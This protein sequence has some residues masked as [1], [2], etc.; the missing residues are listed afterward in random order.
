MNTTKHVAI[1]ASNFFG[2]GFDSRRLH[3]TFSRWYAR[4]AR[5]FFAAGVR[6][7]IASARLPRQNPRTRNVL[8]APSDERAQDIT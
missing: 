4:C 6:L 5:D 2:R 8:L 7:V 3:H 1:L